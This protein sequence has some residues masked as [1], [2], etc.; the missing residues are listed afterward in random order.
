MDEPKFKCFNCKRQS[1]YRN[2]SGVL[3]VEMATMKLGDE[4]ETRTYECEHCEAENR[5]AR[6]G[7]EWMV[8]D[9]AARRRGT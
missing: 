3:R 7:T 8:V 1:R 5:I 4:N 6:S 2:R 9:L